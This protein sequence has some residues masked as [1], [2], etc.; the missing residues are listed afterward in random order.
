MHIYH[1]VLGDD[2]LENI[3]RWAEEIGMTIEEY[4][5][6][7]VDGEMETRLEFEREAK[8]KEQSNEPNQSRD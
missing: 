1:I 3:K 2:E 5:Q 4:I 8:I 7:L 6:S